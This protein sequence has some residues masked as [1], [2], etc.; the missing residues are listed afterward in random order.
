MYSLEL[1]KEPVYEKKN[2]E[3]KSALHHLKM[4]LCHILTVAEVLNPYIYIYIYREREREKEREK[5][6]KK[7]EELLG[8][9][10]S[11][12]TYVHIIASKLIFV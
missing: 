5:R 11:S 9:Y 4:T 8:D 3:F 7:K 12:V 10:L 2:S 1:V 6:K